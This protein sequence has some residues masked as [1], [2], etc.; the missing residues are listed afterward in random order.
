MLQGVTK[1]RTPLRQRG[2]R[3][4]PGAPCS[5]TERDTSV[6]GA[7]VRSE[8]PSISL[9]LSTEFGKPAQLTSDWSRE[10]ALGNRA[11]KGASPDA[12]GHGWA[13]DGGFFSTLALYAHIQLVWYQAIS[14]EKSPEGCRSCC[15]GLGRPAAHGRG[16]GASSG[17]A[18]AEV[19]SSTSEPF[20][21]SSRKLAATSATFR[22]RLEDQGLA[23]RDKPPGL[24]KEG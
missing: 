4:E 3:A 6:A 5:H 10:E 24:G 18:K 8:G 14:F 15:P 16:I 22:S 1:A 19:S 7:H 11:A 20:S 2:A 9:R 17:D 21:H 23:L 12:R 13:L